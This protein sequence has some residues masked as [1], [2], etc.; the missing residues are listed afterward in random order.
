MEVER[1]DRSVFVQELL[2]SSLAHGLRLEEHCDPFQLSSDPATTNQQQQAVSVE[3]DVTKQ[4]EDI[5]LPAPK[6]P[7]PLSSQAQPNEKETDEC[8]PNDASVVYTNSGVRRK[9]H[10]VSYSQPRGLPT[11]IPLEQ[12]SSR[13]ASPHDPCVLNQRG[14]TG[15]RM[16]RMEYGGKTNN[17]RDASTYV[18]H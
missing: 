11:S 6:S 8:P 7:D 13:S 1:A 9:Q 3:S 18:R 17:E 4:K 15:N 5:E 14:A 2:L 10:N 12:Q 16:K